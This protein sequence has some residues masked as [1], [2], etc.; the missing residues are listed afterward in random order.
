MAERAGS[1]K[2]N[3][4]RGGRG[5]SEASLGIRRI[6]LDRTRRLAPARPTARTPSVSPVPAV[7]RPPVHLSLYPPSQPP[8]PMDALYA[9]LSALESLASGPPPA[10]KSAPAA[11]PIAR[12][13]DDLALAFSPAGVGSSPPPSAATLALALAQ[14][15]DGIDDVRPA[16]KCSLVLLL[17]LTIPHLASALP[18]LPPTPGHQELPQGHHPARHVARQGAPGR[19]SSALA[20]VLSAPGSR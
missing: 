16:A 2:R 10:K 11:K 12:Q 6:S 20:P 14:A 9:P 5:E 7:A 15:K 19:R 13:L 8:Y 17:W 18:A 3:R 4:K 1:E